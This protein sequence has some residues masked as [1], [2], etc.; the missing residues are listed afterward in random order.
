MT[1][2]VAMWGIQEVRTALIVGTVVAVASALV[3]VL[4]VLRR[5]AFACHA[6]T[7]LASVGGSAAFLLSI[8]QLWGFIAASVIAGLGMHAVG[9]E[10]LRGRDVSTGIVLGAGMGLTS[11]FLSLSTMRPSSG[12]TSITVLFGSLFAINPGT[13]PVIMILCALCIIMLAVLW[14]PSLFS[15]V[16]PSLA[17][18]RGVRVSLMNALFMVVLGFGVALSSISVG[19]VLSTALLIGPASCGLALATRVRGSMVAA[20]LIAVGCVWG[21]IIV[22][23]ESYSWMHG[24]S[25]SVSFCIVTLIVVCYLVSRV[26]VRLCHAVGTRVEREGDHVR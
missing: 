23:Y 25:W 6:L 17:H 5:Q 16:S 24:Q 11:L 2:V 20:S 21:G 3:G 4:T 22:S 12:N 26:W 7:D 15:T 13:V 10:R 8:N 1:N 18:A 9:I 19:A 14:K